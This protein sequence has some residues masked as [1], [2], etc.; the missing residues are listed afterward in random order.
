MTVAMVAC[1]SN[2]FGRHDQRPRVL[3]ESYFCGFP[4]KSAHGEAFRKR[5]GRSIRGAK[6]MATKRKATKKTTRS[7]KKSTR[8]VK[9]SH[10]KS[11][12]KPARSLKKAARRKSKR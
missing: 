10:K 5:Q 9:R 6:D 11:A 3:A 7:A 4:S 1:G 12:R 8:K 2:G